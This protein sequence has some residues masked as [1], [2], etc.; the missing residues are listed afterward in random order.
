MD[1]VANEDLESLL[2]DAPVAD[3]APA[4]D[5]AATETAAQ[6]A[7][8]E[9]LPESAPPLE[10]SPAEATA[11]TETVSPAAESA[12]APNADAELGK[13]LTGNDPQFAEPAPLASDDLEELKADLRDTELKEEGAVGDFVPAPNNMP[14]TGDAPGVEAP[15]VGEPAS[16]T[17]PRDGQAVV[18][19]PANKPVAANMSFDTGREE[20]ALLDLASSV[21]GQI[22]SSDW[23]ELA[24]QAQVSSY[25]VV[26]DDWLFKISKRL[27]GSGFYYPK[28]WALNP[29]ITNP[30]LIEP[31]MVL[32]F[33]TGSA[34]RPPEVKLGAFTEGEINASPGA[35]RAEIA[36]GA[37]ADDY[38]VWGDDARPGWMEERK[39]LVDQGVYLQYSTAETVENLEESSKTGLVREYDAYEPPSSSLTASPARDQ[40]DRDGIDKNSKIDFKYKEG[41][42]VNTFVTNN[43]VQDLGKIE[44]GPDENLYFYHMDRL[45]VRFEDG[46][47]VLPG[48]RFSVYV[49]EG[50]VRHPNSDR[51]GNRYT[52]NGHVRVV[53]K[54]KD[55]LWEV[56]IEDTT[57]LVSRGSR[58]TVHTPRIQR[59]IQN[60]NDRLVEAAVIA[61]FQQLQSGVSFGDV[62]YVDRGRADGL[63]VGNVLEAY[64]FRDRSSGKAIAEHPTY[65]TGELTVITLTDNF[66]TCLVTNSVRDFYVGD[67][68]VTKTKE[69]AL[70]SSK[71]ARARPRGARDGM[72]VNAL[73]ELDVELKVDDLND[74]LLDQ[75]DKIQLSEDELA[76]LE[77][78][79]R[80]KS[81][82]K[83]SERDLK[84]LER[85]ERE[86]EGA[87]KLLNEAKL[88]E[89]K[90][91]EGQSLN[92]VE[93]KRG[94]QQQESLNE[95]E[96][97]LGKRYLDEELNSKD[98][99]YGLSEFDIEEIDELLNTEKP[100]P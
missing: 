98:N 73:E 63:E 17:G 92:E 34:G 5:A 66:A 71:A 86:I 85:L 46:V 95:I 50:K 7:N 13:E 6:P 21:Q 38:G 40:Y 75:A 9:P 91:L 42:S 76:E 89:D 60:F 27:F 74:S 78:Q 20:K 28:I 81:V 33:T 10:A 100:A 26:K 35:G 70:R 45:Y 55:N 51:S 24:T 56:Q 77:R 8:L 16:L 97:N 57:G 65:K 31:G 53:S 61:S 22:S 88:D 25:T 3:A 41:F 32:H 15:V 54:T 4:T 58:I 90:L 59:L 84:S 64:G 69:A 48:D 62:V 79:E 2:K 12:P 93:Q 39:A 47:N 18:N 11:A 96:A 80:E 94:L 43:P 14:A 36:S 67:V 87:E 19:D 49:A 37:G 52:I 1:M 83:D 99:P 68:A 44:A 82:I 29:F 72:D 30:H 23:N